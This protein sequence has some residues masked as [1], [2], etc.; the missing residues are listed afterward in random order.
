MASLFHSPDVPQP[1]PQPVMPLPDDEAQRKAKRRSVA[2]QRRRAGRESTIL[3]A[4]GN[5]TLG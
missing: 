4:L 1:P 3:S 5:E 2:L